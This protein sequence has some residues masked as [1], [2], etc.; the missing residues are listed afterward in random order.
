MPESLHIDRIREQRF[1]FLTHLAVGNALLLA[2][3]FDLLRQSLQIGF[4]IGGQVARLERCIDGIPEYRA[5]RV[6]AGHYRKAVLHSKDIKQ[7]IFVCRICLGI[8]KTAATL[9]RG[10]ILYSRQIADCRLLGLSDINGVCI[11]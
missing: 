8:D 4:H 9:R 10:G 7:R 2:Y 1:P 5:H 6:I 11:R 3:G